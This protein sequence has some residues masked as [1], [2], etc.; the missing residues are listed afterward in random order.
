M[1]FRLVVKVEVHDNHDVVGSRSLVCVS[2]VKLRD[3]VHEV[4]ARADADKT[5]ELLRSLSKL[6]TGED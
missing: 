6:L 3:Y 4:N 1:S 2:V 5:N